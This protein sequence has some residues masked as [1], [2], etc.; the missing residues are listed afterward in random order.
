MLWEDYGGTPNQLG[1]VGGKN[2]P[3]GETSEVGLHR[4]VGVSPA[5][6]GLDR[7]RIFKAIDSVAPKPQR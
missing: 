5:K 4:T 6:E 7:E 1:V 2:L 3:E